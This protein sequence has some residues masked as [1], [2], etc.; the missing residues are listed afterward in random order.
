MPSPGGRCPEGADEGITKLKSLWVSTVVVLPSS[1]TY[2]DS[3]S[4]EKPIK[5]LDKSEFVPSRLSF[6]ATAGSQEIR[7][8]HQRER[9]AT[10]I[11]ALAMTKGR[12]KLVDKL[13]F[14]GGRFVNRPYGFYCQ[15]SILNSPFSITMGIAT[16]IN[17]LAMTRS[18]VQLD[19]LGFSAAFPTEQMEIGIRRGTHKK[20]ASLSQGRL[21]YEIRK[22]RYRRSPECR[23]Q[24]ERSDRTARSRQQSRHSESE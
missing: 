9:I 7:N 20:T 8:T 4:Q 13:G 16:G 3:F 12:T 19:K 11:N 10:G 2:G 17:A 24:R 21:K 6:R 18:G 15:F 5:L 22:L 1:V 14:G 23:F